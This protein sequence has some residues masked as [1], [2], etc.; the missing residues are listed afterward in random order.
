[1][2]RTACR[3]APHTQSD[4]ALRNI[5]DCT[6]FRAPWTNDGSPP[7]DREDRPKIQ[8]IIPAKRL[9]ALPQ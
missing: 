1:M 9:P 2:R 3:T 4:R 8:R 7:R 6:S 5:F